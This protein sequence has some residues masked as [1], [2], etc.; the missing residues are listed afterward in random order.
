MKKLTIH[1]ETL[2]DLNSDNLRQVVGGQ[3]LCCASQTSCTDPLLSACCTTRYTDT[4][5]CDTNCG[6]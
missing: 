1:R 3:S 2:R 5:T 6:C 4:G